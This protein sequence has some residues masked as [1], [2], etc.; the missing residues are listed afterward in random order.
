KND[1]VFMKDKSNAFTIEELSKLLKAN[2]I[3]QVY[4]VGI[5]LGECLS[6]TALDG[7]ARGYDVTVI[8]EGVRSKKASK[9]AK[10]MD[11]LRGGGVELITLDEFIKER[12]EE[13]EQ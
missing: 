7:V 11:E 6:S 10:L 13:S 1:R 8:E 3:R 5:Y 9:S 4:L 2:D 12:N